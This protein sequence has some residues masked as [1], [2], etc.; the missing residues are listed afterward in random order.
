MTV[1]EARRRFPVL[2]RIAYLNAGT[3]GP[4]SQGTCAAMGE[5]QA[6]TLSEGRGG[7]AYFDAG[8]ELAQRLRERLS[9]LLGVS[10]DRLLLT[11][12]TTEGCNIVI[13]GLRLGPDDEI[14]ITD[15]EH[16]GLE[17]PVRASGAQVRVAPVVG[18]SPEEVLAAICGQVTPRTRL[19]ALSH[20]LWLNGQVL[21]LAEIK[22]AVGALLLVDGAQSVGS[23]PVDASVADFYTVS[24]QK[25]LCGP[26]LTGALYVADPDRLRP[27]M[28][29]FGASIG[30]G[31]ERLSVTHHPVSAVAGLL[32][33]LE[34]RPDWA[35]GHAGRMAAHCR[36][37]LQAAG[38]QVHTTAGSAGLV[39]CNP[40]DDPDL[41]VARCRDHGV[42][43]RSLP[44]GWLRASCG[45]WTDE[46]DVAR[47]VDALVN[48]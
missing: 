2:E 31:A 9:S 17:Q 21:P 27:Q 14:V 37:A 22:R 26:E 35:F 24:G 45:W 25:W 30:D 15:G 34:E 28:A 18:Q 40:P 38:L 8:H 4:L 33:A 10:T 47:L 32:T 48:L 43:I 36:G 11:G 16:P 19:V 13:T 39:S 3:C 6:R 41:A 7:R 23:I 44:N 46:T 1:A 42:I 29:G 20:V 5:W 12:S